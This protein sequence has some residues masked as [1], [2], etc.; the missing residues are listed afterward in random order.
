[1]GITVSKSTV[2]TVSF[3]TPQ[4]IIITH[5]DDSIK[6]GNGTYLAAVTSALALKVDNSAVTQPISGTVSTTINYYATQVDQPDSATT[7]VGKA[8]I[9]SGNGSAVWQIQKLVVT[10]TVTTATWADSDSNFDN[11]W[12]NRASLSYG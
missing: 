8:A 2:A 10:G 9:G 7:Y 11:V 1:M 4:E 5:A 6:I 3:S 12:T